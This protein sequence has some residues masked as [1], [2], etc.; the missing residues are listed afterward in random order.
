VDSFSGNNGLY[1]NLYADSGQIVTDAGMYDSRND[2]PLGI[3]RDT[4]KP[5]IYNDDPIIYEK[6]EMKRYN[7]VIDALTPKKGIFGGFA[8][9]ST[10]E[11][12]KRIQVYGELKTN[13]PHSWRA[14]SWQGTGKYDGATRWERHGWTPLSESAARNL[15]ITRDAINYFNMRISGVIIREPR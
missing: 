12:S 9:G 2:S 15:S 3:Y 14:W 5:G 13:T 4:S 11:G 1:N 6:T 10:F 8:S 7:L